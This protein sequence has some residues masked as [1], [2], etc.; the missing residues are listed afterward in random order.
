MALLA[1]GLDHRGLVRD[2]KPLVWI[3]GWK[4]GSNR[5]AAARREYDRRYQRSHQF[6]P[7]PPLWPRSASSRRMRSL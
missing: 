7:M 5:T 6:E 4:S 1:E 2:V 3:P